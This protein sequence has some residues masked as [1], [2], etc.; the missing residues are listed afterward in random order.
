MN[1]EKW[2]EQKF[3]EKINCIKNYLFLKT[4]YIFECLKDYFFGYVYVK[5]QDILC[6]GYGTNEPSHKELYEISII[7][8]RFGKGQWFSH[9]GKEICKQ[10]VNELKISDKKNFYLQIYLGGGIYQQYIFSKKQKDILINQL[11]PLLEIKWYE[12]NHEYV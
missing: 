3:K 4:K 10:L 12:R 7:C 6:G 9:V 1:K 5:Q 2:K 11:E 8:G